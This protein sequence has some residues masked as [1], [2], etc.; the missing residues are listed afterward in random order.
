MVPKNERLCPETREVSLSELGISAE[1]KLIAI[2]SDDAVS[3]LTSGLYV[4]TANE[5]IPIRL[6]GTEAT[7][8]ASFRYVGKT[9]NNGQLL[10]I[11]T[12]GGQ[13]PVDLVLLSLNNR[14]DQTI[15]TFDQGSALYFLVYE[16]SV[17]AFGTPL[18]SA[19]AS[20]GELNVIPLYEVDLKTGEVRLLEPLQMAVMMNGFFVRDGEPFILYHEGMPTFSSFGIYNYARMTSVNVLDWLTNQVWINDKS[21]RITTSQNGLFTIQVARAYGFDMAVDLTLNEIAR[22]S[23]YEDIMTPIVLSAESSP[24]IVVSRIGKA[25]F[26][27][28]RTSLSDGSEP[29]WFSILDYRKL[30]LRN[31]CF[32]IKNSRNLS[33]VSPDERHISF[34]MYDEEPNSDRATESLILNL[35]T[36]QFSRVVGFKIIDWLAG[37]N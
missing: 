20:P 30:T 13:N 5:P 36:G 6:Q 35:E 27:V 29:T 26:A 11:H 21:A 18:E 3:R 16:N 23:P 34:V 17:V 32:D 31:Y 14:T 15:S 12:R 22:S 9:S 2:Q 7:A 19:L 33:A 24:D 10:L 37:D 25:I 1:E 28:L 4:I 8:E